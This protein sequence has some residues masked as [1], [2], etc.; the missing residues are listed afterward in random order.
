MPVHEV[1]RPTPYGYTAFELQLLTFLADLASDVRR[2]NGGAHLPDVW[3]AENEAL[4]RCLGFGLQYFLRTVP[5][6]P[7]AMPLPSS[8]PKEPEKGSEIRTMVF[9]TRSVAVRYGRAEYV[10]MVGHGGDGEMEPTKDA[11]WE[12]IVPLT[13]WTVSARL[14]WALL[15]GY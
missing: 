7:T 1:K 4:K 15:E 5:G 11:K 2:Y 14:R 3:E 13:G 8:V 10:W 12:L 6:A 9:P